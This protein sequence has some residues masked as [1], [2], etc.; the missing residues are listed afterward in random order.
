MSAFIVAGGSLLEL[1]CPSTLDR[2]TEQQVS[3]TPIIGGKVKAFVRRGGRRSW[4]IDTA[5]ARPGE[6]STIEAVAR[7]MGPFGWYD[8]AAAI[9]NLLSP[10]ASSFDPAPVNST[11][12]GLVQLPDGTVARSVVHAGTGAVNVGDAHGSYEMVPVRSG[13]PVTVGAWASGGVRFSGFWRDAAGVSITNFAGQTHSFT[14]WEWREN[15]LTPPSGAAFLSLALTT[16]TQYALPSVA[17]GGQGRAELGT[18][19]PKALI[20]SPSHSP[21]ALWQ[22]ANYSNSSY[23]VTEVG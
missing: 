3:F 5:L 18:G 2:S 14:G 13:V 15:T 20:H 6:V 19:C 8:A 17:W 22:G 12:A 11:D 23:R 7:Q 16:G 4:S 10:Q 9:G 1:G 21:I